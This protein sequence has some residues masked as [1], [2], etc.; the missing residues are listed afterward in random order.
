MANVT[1]TTEFLLLRFSEVRELHLVHT[2]FAEYFLLTAISY[3][4]YATIC[5]PLRHDVIMDRGLPPSDMADVIRGIPQMRPPSSSACFCGHWRLPHFL[6]EMPTKL[7]LAYVDVWPNEI[8]LLVG[9]FVLI[10]LPLSLITVSYGSIARAMLRI[11]SPRVRRKSLGTCGCH[12][13]VVTPFYGSNMVVCI[14]PNSSFSG[15]FD[16]FLTLFYTLITPTLNP[17]IY[18]LS[19]KDVK[20]A[21]RRI[22]GKDQSSEK[23]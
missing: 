21:G 6:C 23:G 10:L 15:T 14:G 19:N 7:K 5:I 22:L 8:R 13:L 12:L 11:K 9:T 16:T 4:R 3:H 1:L 17:L 18:T 2:A 20:G